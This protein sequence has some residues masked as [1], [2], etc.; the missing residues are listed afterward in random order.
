MQGLY[1]FGQV[2]AIHPDV[3]ILV[4]KIVPYTKYN[5]SRLKDKFEIA[6]NIKHINLVRLLR[7]L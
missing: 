3:K 4:R 1:P 5:Y 6:K 2:Q 7:V